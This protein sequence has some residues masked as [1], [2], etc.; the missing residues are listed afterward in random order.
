M[1]RKQLFSALI[2]LMILALGVSVALAQSS[3]SPTDALLNANKLYENGEFSA[4]AKAYEQLVQ[5]GVR[6]S[7]LFYNLGNAYFKQGD[8]GRAILNYRRAAR[9]AP[10]DADIRANLAVARNKTTDRIQGSSPAALTQLAALSERW[11]TLNELA[12]LALGSWALLAGLLIA[13][14]QLIRPAARRI[15]RYG[16]AVVAVLFTGSAAMLA[17]RIITE[18]NQPAA[19][20]VAQTVDVTSGP[21]EQY[22]TEFTLHSGAEVSLLETRGKWVRLSLPGNDLQG[23]APTNAVQAIAN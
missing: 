17:G 8:L 7:V 19:V 3:T 20:I 12:W 9:L 11:L 5:T 4:A 10:R 1:T 2:W 18:Q 22:I 21:G 16:I 23:W 13:T 6:D 15:L 14:T